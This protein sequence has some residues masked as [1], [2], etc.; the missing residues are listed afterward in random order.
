ME[1]LQSLEYKYDDNLEVIAPI[2]Y[3]ARCRI[4]RGGRLVVDRIPVSSNRI[5]FGDSFLTT[6]VYLL[7]DLSRWAR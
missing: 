3:K 7:V 5:Y 1:Y 2:K 6:I 4:G